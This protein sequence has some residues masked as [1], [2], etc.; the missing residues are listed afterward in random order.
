MKTV[1]HK[2]NE[3]GHMNHGWLNTYHSFSFGGYNNPDKVHF[4]ALRVLN[5]DDIAGGMGFGKHPHD[6]MEIITIPLS[7]DLEH[8][9]ST[10][11]HEIIKQHDV[12]IMSAGSGIAH[13][14]KNANHHLPVSL[15][16]IWVF[17]KERNITPRYQQKTFN[18]SDRV[19]KLLTVV[20][21]DNEEA[22][23]INQD[24][25]FTLGNLEKDKNVQYQFHKKESGVYAFVIKGSVIINNVELNERDALGISEIEALDIKSTTEAEILLIEV[26]M[27][28]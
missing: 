18:P 9:D 8:Q 25:W 15:L 20:A 28:F 11:R 19:N 17:P 1:L 24:A 10:G 7:G 2:A 21:P 23:F 6:N 22:V 3:R 27:N 12:Q 13:S 16:Q 4:G 26:P 14:E 5:D